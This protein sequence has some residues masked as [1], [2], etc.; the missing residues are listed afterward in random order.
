MNDELLQPLSQAVIDGDPDR[1][2]ELAARALS[3][4]A[5]P[6][7]AVEQV[8]SP[9]MEEV[10]RLY[11]EGEYFIPELVMAGEAMKAAMSVLGPEMV[12]REQVRSAPGVVVI[13][14]VEGDIHEIGKSLVA[15][16]LE[17]AGFVVHDLGVDVP[18]A[19]FVSRARE[20]DAD[21]VGLSALLTTTMRNQQAV[22]E[23]LEEAGMRGRVRVVIG[24]A[25][26]SPEWA[27]RIGADGYA[28]NAREAVTVV[29]R[30]VGVG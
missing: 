12:A 27:E 19:A 29:R 26:A 9:A 14:T 18:A 15:T 20:V 13:G 28:E 10:G 8:L 30:L 24:G 21:V 5:D 25:P 22:I 11:E 7:G 16:M 2:R 23:A 17:A 3:A 1:A 4:G 6:L